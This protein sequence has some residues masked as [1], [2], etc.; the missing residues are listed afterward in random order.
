MGDVGALYHVALSMS[1]VSH[2][3]RGL[4]LID[5]MNF[6]H[7]ANHTKSLSVGNQPTQ[8]IFGFIRTLRPTVTTFSQ[9]TPIV[10]WD[11]AS[12][13]YRA[14]PEYKAS[15]NAP[16]KTKT[17]VKMA[18]LRE[19]LNAQ[20]PFVI[21]AL[22]HLAV[23]QIS[24]INLEADDLAAILTRKRMATPDQSVML[25]SADKDW[26]QLVQPRVMWLD[27]I[28][29]V[30]IS[31][32][33]ISKRL[34]WDM[35]AKDIVASTKDRNDDRFIGVP[36]P[37]AWLEMKALMGDSSDEIP[38]AGGIGPKGAIDL[39]QEF[40]SVS[41]FL[42]RS[43][44]GSLPKL[45]KKFEKLAT[46][47]ETQQRYRRNLKLMDLNHPEIPQAI[48]LTI[49]AGKYDE[50]AFAQLC[51]DLMFKSVVSDIPGWCEPF[52]RVT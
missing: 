49:D 8:A 30:R 43:I 23:R 48:N 5:G 19:Q 31:S 45:P 41:D 39:I 6:L 12:W 14:F 42:N 32:T 17:D 2:M 20:K 13:R 4:L 34:G 18:G 38:G 40:G 7:A 50:T 25:V 24:A 51:N 16:P 47:D 29:D 21:E 36:S 52:R 15:R 27:P 35:D 1:G 26:I 33:S 44:D 28:R 22:R 3:S 46:D 9:L 37:R 10:L 11:G